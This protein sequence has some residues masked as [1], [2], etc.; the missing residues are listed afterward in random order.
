MFY[1]NQ[2]EKSSREALQTL[3]LDKTSDTISNIN[4]KSYEKFQ[5]E[6]NSQT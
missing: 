2:F 5:K 4:L 3:Q 1:F 6:A